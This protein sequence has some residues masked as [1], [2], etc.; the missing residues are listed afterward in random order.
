M[1]KQLKSRERELEKQIRRAHRDYA[2]QAK[3]MEN[4]QY[5]LASVQAEFAEAEAKW[6]RSMLLMKE[7]FERRLKSEQVTLAEKI[8]FYEQ[9]VGALTDELDVAKKQSS[10][11]KV[12][13]ET[14]VQRP[15]FEFNKGKVAAERAAREDA[16]RKLRAA[17]SEM[18]TLRDQLL[19]A[20][21]EATK[22]KEEAALAAEEAAKTSRAFAL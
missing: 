5:R 1:N 13:S 18:D 3:K 16:E 15:L 10:S 9:R 7:D 4:V 22:A 17:Q 20:E 21:K 11:S 6:S 8:A 19:A 12:E 2:E 14:S